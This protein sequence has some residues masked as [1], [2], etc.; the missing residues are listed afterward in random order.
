MSEGIAELWTGYREGATQDHRDRLI[1]HYSPLVKYVAGR[2]AVGLPPNV[3]QTDLVSY[4]IFGLI[5]AIEKFDPVRGF[6]F[7]TYAVARIKG[8]ILDELRSNDW[9]PRSVR[10]KGRAVE[11]A[12][13]ELEATL[14]RSPTDVE[15]AT[16]LGYTEAEL[17][18]VLGQLSLTGMAALD[19]MLGDRSEST[20]LADTI[21]DSSEGPSQQLELR[22]MRGQLAEAIERMPEREKVVLTL[23]YFENL[24]LLQIGQ[25]LQVTESRVSQIHTKAVLQLRGRLQ[26][27]RRESA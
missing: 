7:E 22:E 26:A 25:V 19:E 8:A 27:A 14:G 4:G 17:L 12:I 9:V 23:Y 20:T 5:D 11:R 13:S 16:E 1:L 10:T 6:K 3:E 18:L 24:T 2:V 21:P 15:L